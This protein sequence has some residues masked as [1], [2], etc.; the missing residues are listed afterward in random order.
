MR[1]SAL[2]VTHITSV[3]MVGGRY[4]FRPVCSCGHEFRGYAAAHAAQ[5]LVDAHAHVDAV[6]SVE[7]AQARRVD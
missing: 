5:I 7:R 3:A 4:P 6:K 1:A 2:V